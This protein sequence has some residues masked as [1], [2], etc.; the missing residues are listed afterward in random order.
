MKVSWLGAG[1]GYVGSVGWVGLGQ[2]HGGSEAVSNL[3]LMEDII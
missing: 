1:L 3:I 2:G